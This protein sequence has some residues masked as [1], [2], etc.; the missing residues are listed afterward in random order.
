MPHI[1]ISKT[2]QNDLIKACGE[3]IRDMISEEVRSCRFFSIIADEATDSSNC[4]QLS[5]VF[6]FVD[7][8]MDVREEFMG[9]V[10]CKT[11]VTGEALAATNLDTLNEWK[12][13]KH[14]SLLCTLRIACIKSLHFAISFCTRHKKYDGCGK[15]NSTVF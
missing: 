3:H 15:Q 5:I 1:Y 8:K 7:D 12:L 6:R 14:K 2:I 11:G 10:E 13:D 4:E 9:F